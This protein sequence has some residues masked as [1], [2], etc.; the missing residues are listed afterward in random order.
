LVEFTA[1]TLGGFDGL[2]GLDAPDP[3]PPQ[4]ANKAAAKARPTIMVL[5]VR[6]YLFIKT[7]N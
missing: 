5:F 2:V 4:A 1:L 7:P 6:I 3:E